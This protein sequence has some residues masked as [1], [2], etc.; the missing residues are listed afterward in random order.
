[1]NRILSGNL[2]DEYGA[3]RIAS[4]VMDEDVAALSSFSSNGGGSDNGDSGLPDF[5][6]LFNTK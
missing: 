4:K 6:E 5:T 3:A 1:M 2:V